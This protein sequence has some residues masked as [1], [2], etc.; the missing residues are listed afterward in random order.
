LAVRIFLN[1]V[2]TPHGVVGERQRPAH[3]T[4]HRIPRHARRVVR[5]GSWQTPFHDLTKSTAA[6]RV[7]ETNPMRRFCRIRL[8][9]S[10]PA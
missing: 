2:V 7:L 4:E 5:V 8:W 3:T 9:R 6:V 1:R 10:I